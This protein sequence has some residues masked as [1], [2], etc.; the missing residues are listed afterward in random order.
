MKE[1]KYKG[2][3]E[4]DIYDAN[5]KFNSKEYLNIAILCFA[6]LATLF[7]IYIFGLGFKVFTLLNLIKTTTLMLV[8]YSAISFFNYFHSKNGI[9]KRKKRAKT[10][11]N[12][13]AHSI[14]LD[15]DNKITKNNIMD[16]Q[17]YTEVTS[18]RTVNNDDKELSKEEK[19]IKYFYLLDSG[20]KIKVL[21]EIKSTLEKDEVKMEASSLYLLDDNDLVNKNLPVKKTLKLK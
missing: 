19:I 15:N 9:N 1:I 10:R 17:I 11:L 14:N 7:N 18:T 13:L 8:P 16:A 12:F 2:N 4:D 6:V 3:L 5:N 21:R 20:D